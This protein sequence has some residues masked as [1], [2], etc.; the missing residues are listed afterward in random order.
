MEKEIELFNHQIN[1]INAVKGKENVAFFLEM[2]LGKSITGICQCLIFDNPRTLL[3]CPKS[4]ILTWKNTFSQFFPELKVTDLT[5][6]KNV[7]DFI[8]FGII[9]YDILFRR[10]ELLDL[11]DYTLM[12]D[13]SSKIMHDTSKRTKFILKMKPKN[14]ILLSG[15]P[16][17]GKYENLYT[18]AK[19]LGLE[20]N[21]T[22]W[23]DNFVKWRLIDVGQFRIKS[24]YGYKN[25][26][27]MMKELTEHGAIFMATED[28]ISLPSINKQYIKVETSSDYR[29]FIKN[30]IVVVDEKELVGDN[31]LSKRLYARMLCGSLNKFKL[32]CLRDLLE[33]TNERVVVFYNFKR[34]YEDIVKVCKELEK[35]FSSVNG[36]VKDLDAYEKFDNSVILCQYQSASYGLNLQKACRMIYFDLPESVDQYIQS[37]ARIHRIGQTNKCWYFYI[38]CQGSVEEDILDALDSG[39]DYNDDLFK[40]YLEKVNGK[41]TNSNN[42]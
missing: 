4:L 31:V 14:K 17:A 32:E 11:T 34:D 25:V 12:L 39:K 27:K 10:K 6:C 19:L 9:N 40:K 21:K 42:N 7:L 3:V 18:Q 26:D 38:L 36:D 8:G 15:S 16:C 28:V 13:E 37:G 33:D 29:K 5:K 2:G 1:A 20:Y 30:R 41:E 23:W 22:Q 35:N 24:A